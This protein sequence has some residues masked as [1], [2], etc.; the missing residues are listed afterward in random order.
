MYMVRCGR[1][2]T[3]G[4]TLSLNA[5]GV[6]AMYTRRWEEESVISSTLHTHVGE[7]R[8]IWGGSF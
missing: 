2:D 4:H 7:S 6:A 3:R 8:L 5:V 1:Y